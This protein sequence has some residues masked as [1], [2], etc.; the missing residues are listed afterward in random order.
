MVV[1]SINSIYFFTYGVLYF[2]HNT[3][4]MQYN[5]CFYALYSKL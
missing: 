4:T 1:C 5:L 3:M 2:V